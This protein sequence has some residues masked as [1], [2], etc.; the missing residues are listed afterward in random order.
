MFTLDNILPRVAGQTEAYL[1]MQDAQTGAIIRADWGI[2]DPGG[3]ASLV[4][5]CL[6]TQCL[7][8][9]F[10]TQVVA[11]TN[12]LGRANHALDYLETVQRSS[13]LTDLRDC[14][15]DSSPDAGF[16]LQAICPALLK[17]RETELD[18]D[19]RVLCKRFEVFARRMT[20]GAQTGGFHTPN[21][22][23]VISAGLALAGQLFPD[24]PVR[25]T[26]DAYLAEGIDLD[27]DGFYLERSAGVYDAIC[28]K[29]LIILAEVLEKPE[30]LEYV[31]RNLTANLALF[32]A[33]GTI[34]TGLSR[35]QDYGTLS[36]PSALIIPYLRLG[37]LDV[38]TWLQEKINREKTNPDV[39]GLSQY[40][41]AHGEP[42]ISPAAK[43]PAGMTHFAQNQLVR[44]QRKG[45]SASFFGN[46][47]RLFNIKS[48]SAYL[49]SV[50]I[51][52]SYFG[53]GQFIA[54]ALTVSGDTI[55]LTSH[56]ERY[57]YRPGYEQPLGR[58][59][60]PE[61]YREMRA[62]RTIRRLPPAKSE[63]I[64]TEI[65]GGFSIRFRTLEGLDRAPLQIALDFA[66]GGVWETTDTSFT[67]QAGQVIFLKNGMGTMRYGKN[68]ITLSPGADG[69][70]MEK[71]RDA[72]PPAAGLVR[73]LLTFT[74]PVDHAFTITCLPTPI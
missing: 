19:W 16:I 20:E 47:S 8:V 23:W 67:P 70:R 22:R 5:L 38:A 41:L 54:E 34:E 42:T 17:A 73:V 68:K 7:R 28:N 51:H 18:A 66:A 26:I 52:Q 40:L 33:D 10:P 31:R 36:V 29:S 71:M 37:F 9:Q 45:Y 69:H 35:R 1:G 53:V 2:D 25:E 21:H 27:A 59:V 4:A 60:P 43:P 13:G 14:N 44:V 61:N 11:P 48:G 3:T 64:A 39:Y 63:L 57:P 65:L 24:I 62:E 55:T 49:A 32:H 15:F 46:M 72:E 30:L 56:G 58:P 12:A 6:W 50:S 74:T